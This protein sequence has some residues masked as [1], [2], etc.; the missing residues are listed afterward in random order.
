MKLLKDYE[1]FVKTIVAHQKT[2]K[3]FHLTRDVCHMNS[4]YKAKCSGLCSSLVE[5]YG[6][7]MISQYTERFD[8]QYNILLNCLRVLHIQHKL[9][10]DEVI[11]KN[12]KI[13]VLLGITG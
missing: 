7:K 13:C 9:L 12:K 11:L 8:K 4:D 1:I 2:G 5:I 6:E 3:S 10:C